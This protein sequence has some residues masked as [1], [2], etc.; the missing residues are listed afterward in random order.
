MAQHAKSFAPITLPKMHHA[1]MANKLNEKARGT[2]ISLVA[3]NSWQSAKKKKQK[4]R[5]QDKSKRLVPK[6]PAYPPQRGSH[7]SFIPRAAC[8]AISQY[9]TAPSCEQ[10]CLRNAQITTRV[11]PKWAVETHSPKKSGKWRRLEPTH[12]RRAENIGGGNELYP[13]R[14]INFGGGNQLTLT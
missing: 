5:Y 2:G 8:A 12:P 7:G 10:A 3:R 9:A 13:R 11:G 14:A 1:K 6:R 4:P